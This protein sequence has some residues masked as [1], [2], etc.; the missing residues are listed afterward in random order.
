M[1]LLLGGFVLFT[2]CLLLVL[3][4]CS[5]LLLIDVFVVG[6]FCVVYVL[7]VHML[8]VVFA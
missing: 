6:W 3:L 4:S 8:F 2:C 5:C 1:F 7:F